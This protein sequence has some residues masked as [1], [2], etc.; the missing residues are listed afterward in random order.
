MSFGVLSFGKYVVQTRM[1]Y[2]NT[3]KDRSVLLDAYIA[4]IPDSLS[5]AERR[6]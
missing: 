2:F 4:E 6:I 1:V 3:L 5:R